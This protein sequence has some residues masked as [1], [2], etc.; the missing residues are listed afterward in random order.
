VHDIADYLSRHEPFAGLEPKALAEIAAKVEIEYFGVGEVIFEQGQ[1]PAERVRIVVAGAVELLDRGRTLDLIGPGELFGH[2]SMLAGLPTGFA[3]RAHE[4]TL[5]YRLPSELLVP[6]LTR[7]EGLRYVA[8]SL[9]ARGS[10]PDLARH[11]DGADPARRPVAAFISEEV[12][13]CS[14]GD[15]V[16]D[17]AQRMAGCGAS[18]AIVP[19]AEGEYGI[20]TDQD[21]RVRV[22]A[23]DVPL[24]A[25]I[26]RAMTAPAFIVGGSQLAAD[27]M[28]EMIN[29]GIRHVPV[30]SP[31]RELLGVVTEIDLLAA[32]T[33]TPFMVRRQIARASTVDSLVAAAQDLRPTVIA[34]HEAQ[35]A[36]GQLCAIIAAFAD[37]ITRRA[38]ELL[39]AEHGELPPLLWLATGSL[40]RHEAFPSSDV[41]SALAW[42]GDATQEDQMLALATEVSEVLERCRF[43]RDLNAASATH[44][45]FARSSAD[46]R[47]TVADWFEHPEDTRRLIVVSVLADLRP[48]HG[49][50]ALEE[51]FAGVWEG[52]RHPIF[53]N[54]LRRLALANR[55]PTGF[56]RDIVVEHS[57]EHRGR[58]DIKRG[59]FL[60]IVDLARYLALSTG[61]RATGTVERLRTAAAAGALGA[62]DATTLEE[63]FALFVE[64]R[65]D[66]QIRQLR[67]GEQPSD[68]IDPAEL[69]PLTRRYLREAFRFIARSQR[70]L[71]AQ[72]VG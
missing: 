62:E 43:A 6:L 2:P 36:P 10:R 64:L 47:R 38:L 37:A 30:V 39:S 33:R 13:T 48:V 32:D 19:L 55:P 71:P 69:G 59:G 72:G 68:F 56:L 7:P 29:R 18:C 50:A 31:R 57:G 15:S 24:E 65:M 40:G 70:K 8:R 35:V 67:A 11:G 28:V 60:P 21:L 46:W 51:A 42:E 52:H 9:L 34:L 27:V 5:C 61:T 25:P 4:D 16:R 22:V 41:D 45:L 14:P 63:A 53:M 54:Q 12:V 3:A 58:L 17:V 66:H 23:G 44:P 20:V 49:S 26:E 1:E